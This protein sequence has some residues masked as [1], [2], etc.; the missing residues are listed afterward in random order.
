MTGEQAS[1]DAARRVT[2]NE[3]ICLLLNIYNFMAAIPATNN[4]NLLYI[5]G[6]TG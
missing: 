5:M 6:W 3:K 1:R 4:V 2:A